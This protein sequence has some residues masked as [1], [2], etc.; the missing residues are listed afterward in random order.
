MVA[1]AFNPST[2]EADSGGSHN[3]K[4]DWSTEWVLGQAR[5][6]KRNTLS[7]KTKEKDR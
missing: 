6:T 5:D 7:P 4:L 1:H 2:W 3:S